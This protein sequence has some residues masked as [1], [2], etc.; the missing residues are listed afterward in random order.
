MFYFE[1]AGWK[2]V[3]ATCITE[4]KTG[5]NEGQVETS[6][7]T[8]EITQQVLLQLVGFKHNIPLM[9]FNLSWV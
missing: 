3:C 4:G 1:K 8:S 5:Y 7:L 2:S 9:L 6:K